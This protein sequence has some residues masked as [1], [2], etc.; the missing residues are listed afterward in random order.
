MARARE[1]DDRRVVEAALVVFWERGFTTTSLA[2]LEAATG[3]S[4]S[5]I[6]AAY[7]SK[8]GL[9]ERSARVYL[10]EIMDPLLRPMEAEGA[11]AQEIAEYFRA[12]GRLVAPATTPAGGRGCL[13]LNTAMELEELDPAAAGMVTDYRDRL[14]AAFLNAVQTIDSIENREARADV[15]TAGALGLA[16]TARFDRAAAVQT[17][18]TIA[19]DVLTW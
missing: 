13:M 4:R 10:S 17:A 1:F 19:A 3:L 12:T 5:S 6:Y 14:R 2:H 15:L 18:E 11:G 8:R 7:G 9:Y 16:A